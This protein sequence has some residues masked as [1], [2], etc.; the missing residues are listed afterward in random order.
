MRRSKGYAQ[1]KHRRS[2]PSL[3]GA[4]VRIFSIAEMQQ[5]RAELERVST[6]K[7]PIEQAAVVGWAMGFANSY[8]RTER[9]NLIRMF[10]KGR[11]EMIFKTGNRL[12]QGETH[13]SAS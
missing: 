6:S 5:V 2:I 10:P 4:S 7:D 9:G 3:D 11:A 1:R 12:L 13:E 8:F